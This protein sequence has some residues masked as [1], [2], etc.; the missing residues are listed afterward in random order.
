M[1]NVNPSRGT[2]DVL[3]LDM[4]RR[5]YVIDLICKTYKKHGFTQVETPIIENID[6]LKSSDGGENIKLIFEILKRG[7]DFT[8][9][10]LKELSD[11]GLRYD[12]TLPVSRFYANNISRLPKIF[13][14]FQIGNVFR[15]ERPQ[16]GR[17]RQFMQCDVDIIG[18]DSN[19][20][21]IRVL[22]AV[23]D[24]LNQLKIECEVLIN[25]RKLLNDYIFSFNVDVQDINKIL[26]EL[27][28]IDKIGHDGVKKTLS[29]ILPEK[30][31]NSLVD[32]ID[33][34]KTNNS[35]QL[36]KNNIEKIHKNAQITFSPSLVRGMGYYTGT[37]FEIKTKNN[38]LSI[39][40][41]GRYDNTIGKFLN[42][43]VSACGMSIGFERIVDIIDLNIECVAILYGEENEYS[44]I[45]NAQNNISF[46]FSQSIVTPIKLPKKIKQSFF[47]NLKTIGFT[48]I[49]KINEK[50][51]IN[52]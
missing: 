43:N 45:I 14:A 25:D 49:Y 4:L 2:H 21:E 19:F 1:L 3:P 34:M 29:K 41:G 5:Q 31:L 46:D 23:L 33:K 35:L 32:N 38:N 27:D 39:A 8:N 37:I 7:L 47:S 10:D 28:K 9:T 26:V 52:L 51:L 15:A 42:E 6:R 11:L 24:V 18:D 13:S 30:T 20:A 36:I 48:K 22:A 17:Y 40:G 12:L 50:T 16:K 44:E